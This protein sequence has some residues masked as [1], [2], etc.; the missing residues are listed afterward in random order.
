MEKF[1]VYLQKGKIKVGS[2]EDA[3]V[4][5]DWGLRLKQVL[6]SADIRN[7]MRLFDPSAQAQ[8][9]RCLTPP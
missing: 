2:L 5:A 6:F 7:D 8:L 3:A 9:V 1:Y 4:R